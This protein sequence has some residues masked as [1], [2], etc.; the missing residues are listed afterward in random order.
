M[1]SSIVLI[2]NF[3]QISH[4]FLVFFLLT[5]NKSVFAG[6]QNKKS[7][8][9]IRRWQWKHH[10]CITKVIRVPQPWLSFAVN[11]ILPIAQITV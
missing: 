9:L 3:E 11:M 2:F 7:D 6:M 1:R 8:K 4:I 5:L 10:N